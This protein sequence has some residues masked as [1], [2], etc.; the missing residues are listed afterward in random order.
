M[1]QGHEFGW[2]V[3]HLGFEEGLDEDTAL[4]AIIAATFS[5]SKSE[6]KWSIEVAKRN[7][8]GVDKKICIEEIYIYN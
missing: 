7:A 3:G 5:S 6:Q 8:T 1:G 2:L 4:P